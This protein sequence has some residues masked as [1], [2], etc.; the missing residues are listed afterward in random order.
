MKF[1]VPSKEF[2]NKNG[3]CPQR[4]YELRNGQRKRRKDGSM[5]EQAPQLKKGRDFIFKDGRLFYREDLVIVRLKRGR[6]IGK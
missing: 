5:Y 2:H 3:L 1:T 6:K 4:A